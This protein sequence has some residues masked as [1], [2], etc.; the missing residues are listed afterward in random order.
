MGAS[1]SKFGS[2]AST[3]LLGVGVAAAA[4]AA[5]SIKAA[6][7]ANEAHLKLQNTFANNKALSDSSVEAFEAQA[8]A[9]RDLTGVDDEAIISG[10][11]LLGQMNRT[12][13]EVLQLTPLIVDL[14]EKFDIDLQA[15]FKAVGKAADGNTGALAR[16]VGQV[17]VGQT[18]AETFANVLD[19]LGKSEGFAAERAE[20]EPWR[21]LSAQFEEIAEQIGQA[22]LPVLQSAAEL[23]TKLS[24]S[25]L[26]WPKVSSSCRCSRWPRVST[27]AAMR[28][29][30]SP[31]PSS[32][33]SRSSVISWIV[34]M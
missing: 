13:S 17:E 1:T 10:Q 7:E 11:A 8:D 30:S 2:L 19:A 29:T 33:R 28:W 6:I 5:V 22:L 21:V 15:A 26:R 23:L 34:Q 4:G 16:Y 14:S 27:R 3:A 20:A 18:E 12:G 25:S 9:L 24:P 32:T 31:T